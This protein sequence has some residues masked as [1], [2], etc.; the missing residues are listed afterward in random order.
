[1]K[2]TGL[3]DG[4]MLITLPVVSCSCVSLIMSASIILSKS[5]FWLLNEVI[6]FRAAI[7]VVFL[8]DGRTVVGGNLF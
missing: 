5:F 8:S 2:V 7:V 3:Y 6:A 4:C 1:M